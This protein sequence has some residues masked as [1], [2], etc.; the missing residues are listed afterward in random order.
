[1]IEIKN[2][3]KTYG[4]I[5]SVD[6][7]SAS[8]KE[9]SIF[10]LVGS[11]G[12]GKST[13]LRMMAGILA[14]DEGII[15]ADGAPVWE[16][17]EAKGRIFY[18]SDDHYFIQHSTIRENAAF[19][20]SVYPRFDRKKA[21][22]LAGKFGLSPTR[23]IN[24]FS[25]GMQ[26]QASVILALAAHP[27]YLL[28]DETFD[29]LDPV[30]RQLVKGLIAAEVAERDM[31]VILA[32]HNLRELEDICDRLALLHK[33]ELLFES[34]IDTLKDNVRTVQAMFRT[35]MP[36]KLECEGLRF[37][38]P[39]IRGSMLNCVVSGEEGLCR[40]YFESLGAEFYEFIPL[41]LEEIFITEMEER[42]YDA[43]HLIG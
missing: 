9:G 25:K 27:D 11:N 16:N 37:G 35:E 10:G 23:K 30:V 41:T 20:S 32:S 33:G 38:E 29:G 4:S 3:T 7:L 15:N 18:L 24:T 8:I 6:S 28:C 43:N 39:A 31:T 12:S 40:E 17:P 34:E 22:E 21:E 2:L 14:P 36:Q 13:L 42:G 19:L 26:K 1:M 5:K